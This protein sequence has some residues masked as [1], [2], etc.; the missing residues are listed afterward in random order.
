MVKVEPSSSESDSDIPQTPLAAST[1]S[2][3]P[4]AK[5]I[6]SNHSDSDHS[7]ASHESEDP[8][9][10]SQASMASNT[11]SS[12]KNTV[13][14]YLNKFPFVR[15]SKAKNSVDI[16]LTDSDDEV[17]IVKCP[18]SINARKLLH[19]AKL[20]SFPLETVSKINSPHTE[21]QLEGFVVKNA[22]QKPVTIMSG[23]EFKSFVPVGTI[24]IRETLQIEKIP[25]K[26]VRS[27]GQR[28][29]AIDVDEEIPFP[30]EIRV[31]HPLLG[32]KY[33]AALKLPKRVKKA[34][35]L[36][37]QRADSCYLQKDA[38]LGIV[39]DA[40]EEQKEHVAEKKSKKRKHDEL[41]LSAD[42]PTG[43]MIKML[44]KEE[45]QSPS[46]KKKVKK[47]VA[48]PVD[49]DLSWLNNM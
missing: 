45:A 21:Q 14:K 29:A 12:V 30:E 19:G 20:E 38:N 37:Q 16:D 9:P 11:P 43:D 23:T 5:K 32:L 24:Q 13:E 49:D 41:E 17:W 47:E 1:Q 39:A 4:P 36:A 15:R 26:F 40:G 6:K 27:E 10:A 7:S 18:T 35:S 31:R 2:S 44:I 33:K 46:R 48:Q 28:T 22:I 8:A 25:T 3:P 42:G 34:L